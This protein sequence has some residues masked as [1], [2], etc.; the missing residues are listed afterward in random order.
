MGAACQPLHLGQPPHLGQAGWSI[1]AA[2]AA[3]FS[4]EGTHLQR[5]ARVLNCVEVNSSFH[6]PHQRSTWEKWAQSVPPDFRFSVKVP[7]SITHAKEPGANPA[8]LREFLNQAQGLEEKLAV[9][10]F[11]FPP[12]LTF[13][14]ELAER[15][16]SPMRDLFPGTIVCEPRNASWFSAPAEELLTRLKVTRVA[17]D[18]A[19][20]PEAARPGGFSG[21]HYY[22]LHGSPRVYYSAYSS[23]FL[24]RLS[25][26]L[27]QSS[28]TCETWC[29]FD[30]TASGAAMANLLELSG[31]GPSAT[32]VA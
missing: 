20:S 30:N 16:F 2:C 19:L 32:G 17:A 3:A 31:P 9:L 23:Q 18:P 24:V 11:Q 15:I 14:A 1:P 6:R 26:Q 27:A 28:A 12:K 7:K 8:L 21:C 10:L 13:S 25:Q 22:R 4:G 29:I 5:Y